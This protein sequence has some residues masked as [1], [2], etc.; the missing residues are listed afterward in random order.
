MLKISKTQ[1]KDFARCE[2]REGLREF[3]ADRYIENP[4]LAFAKV[5]EF[6]DFIREEFGDDTELSGEELTKLHNEFKKT[7]GY[8]KFK[9]HDPQLEAFAEEFVAVEQEAIRFAREKFK[10]KIKASEII[11]KQERISFTTKTG[12]TFYTYLD[13]FSRLE[14]KNIIFEVKATTSRKFEELSAKERN[15]PRYFFFTN[16]DSFLT[17]TPREAMEEL[18]DKKYAKMVAKMFDQ[19]NEIGKYIF[20]A[21]ITY[22]IYEN[23]FLSRDQAIVPAEVYLLVLNANYVFDGKTA[24][25]APL[26]RAVGG[27][28]LFKIIDVTR[29][30]QDWQP[31]IAWLAKHVAKAV[32][33]EQANLATPAFQHK[34]FDGR[35]GD[36]D[37]KTVFSKG[38]VLEYIEKHLAF[39]T[40]AGEKLTIVDL[41]ERG[42]YKF[43]DVPVAWLDRPI[44][45]IQRAC[46]D[47]H[48]Q[49]FFGITVDNYRYIM[50]REI[51][52]MI[53]QLK[54]PL[55]HI[56]FETYNA[57]LP[58]FRGEVPYQQSPFQWSLHIERTP[59]VCDY[60]RDHY[61]FLAETFGDEREEFV[62]SLCEH[63]DLRQ[64]GSVMVYNETFEKTRLKELALAFPAYAPQLN[65]IAEHIVDLYFFVRSPREKSGRDAPVTYFYD[66]DL[67]GS[68]SIKKILPVLTE[69]SYDD[70]AVKNGTEAILAYSRFKHGSA[71]EIAQLRAE[72]TKYCGQD[73]WAMVEILRALRTLTQEEE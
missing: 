12:E 34:T 66:K 16:E 27:E 28:E 52:E 30:V 24:H 62:K 69:L 17:V 50:K 8:A 57:P 5:K 31:K 2:T 32:R 23:S 9:H 15:K 59:G 19:L 3:Y 42:K 55:Y 29:F 22:Y 7:P 43:T 53:K 39:V 4:E 54:Y 48:P 13:G 6:L 47:N 49:E 14:D 64:G 45:Q 18:T 10:L 11:H 58:R 1:F 46:Y 33:E 21:A 67:A 36:V 70:L 26:Y 71:N 25:G 61:Q 20:D 41:L 68:Y 37:W 40:P 44:Q 72:L 38:S 51:R 73:T 35:L 60:E 63:V 65:Q 56:D